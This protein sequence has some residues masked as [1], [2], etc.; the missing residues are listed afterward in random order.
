[1][2]TNLLLALFL[3]NVVPNVDF[4]RYAGTWHEVARFPNRFQKS[5]VGD[6]TANYTL[7]TDGK[8]DVVNRCRVQDGTYISVRGI[9]KTAGK[10]LPN[11]MLKVRFAPKFLSFIPQVW[12][13]YHVIM[14]AEDYSYAAVGSPDRRYLW[15]LSRTPELPKAKY[16][17]I[18]E[19]VRSL[20]FDI[21][22]LEPSGETHTT[23]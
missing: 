19:Q 13:P 2:I 15:V 14:L 17:Q 4:E 7:R 5:C 8:I 12:G 1:M 22:K 16:E 18:L 21:R 20:G 11:S 3:Y 6:V 23:G 10:G 9:A